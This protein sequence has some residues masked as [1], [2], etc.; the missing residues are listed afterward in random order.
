MYLSEYYII[1]L[2][3]VPQTE[4]FVSAKHSLFDE[5]IF[6]QIVY[7]RYIYYD[8]KLCSPYWVTPQY[9]LEIR[10]H[11][12]ISPKSSSKYFVFESINIMAYYKSRLIAYK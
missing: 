4:G 7:I 2:T 12:M 8:T 5:P 1:D 9:L 11:G 10:I 3:Q 6:F